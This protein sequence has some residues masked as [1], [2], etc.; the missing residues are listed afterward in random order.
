MS[1]P[2]LAPEEEPSA[3]FDTVPTTQQLLRSKEIPWDIY[4]TAR[5]ISDVDLQ[6]LRR[7]DKRD[8]EQRAILLE[9]GGPAYVSALLTV[10]KN[11]TKDET[12]QYV[13]ALL[14]D[15]IET[16]SDSSFFFHQL[17]EVSEVTGQT[18]DLDPYAILLRLLQRNDWFTE[19]KAARVLSAVIDSR[20]D[21]DSLATSLAE[22]PATLDPIA[23]TISSFLEW[24]LGQ[25]RQ[26]SHPTRA[27]PIAVHCLAVMLGES[28]VRG[29]VFRAG[30]TFLLTPLVRM[31]TQ[32]GQLDIQL[33]YEA[34][35]CLWEISYHKPAAD[36]LAT[37]AVVSGLVDIVRLAKKEKL[38]RVALLTLKNLLA[39]G[40]HPA[41]E[42]AVVEKGLLKSVMTRQEQTW[43]DEDI[44]NLLEWMTDHLEQGVASMTSFERYKKELTK[45]SLIRSP[46]HDDEAFWTE[47]SERLADGNAP[48]LRSLIR[49]LEVSR[50][51]TTLALAC[52]DI[53]QFINHFPHGRGMVLEMGGKTAVMRLMG[54]PDAEVQK[55][56]LVA[57]QRLLLSRDKAGMLSHQVTST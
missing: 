57:V 54:H 19:E 7:Y 34:T 8:P 56:A 48:L 4:M 5:L 50:D 12:V 32:G 28:P 53:S 36:A 10:L 6:L 52:H 16:K 55:E 1:T 3:L 43:D 15:M 9:E 30:G 11:V 17:K 29:I 26:P 31:P 40:S 2:L 45:G 37:A 35:V 42:Y 41:V 25:L 13:L 27:V 20:P 21:K 49:L 18:K 47:N 46:L 22:G 51:T 14:D 24:S 38:V 44:P 33:L 39:D 23:T